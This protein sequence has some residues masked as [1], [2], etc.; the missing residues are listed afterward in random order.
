MEENDSAVMTRSGTNPLLTVV[1]FLA[2]IAGV[3][4]TGS[5]FSKMNSAAR[6]LEAAVGDTMSVASAFNRAN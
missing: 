6:E 4:F 5:H 3:I 2:I 1:L